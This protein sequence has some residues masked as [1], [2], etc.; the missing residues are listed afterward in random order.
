MNRVREHLAVAGLAVSLTSIAA[1]SQGSSVANAVATDAPQVA[2][3]LE[4]ICNNLVPT[5]EATANALAKGGAA[6]T[7][8][9]AEADYVTPA[10]AAAN[11][12]AIAVNSGWLADVVGSLVTT[13]ANGQESAAPPKGGN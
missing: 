8:Q 4:A 3:A 11:A 13:T 5:A 9:S 7:I 2:S 12:A 10:C 6:T 1:C